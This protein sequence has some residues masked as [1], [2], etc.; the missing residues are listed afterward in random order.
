[1]VPPRP[2]VKLPTVPSNNQFKPTHFAASR[3]LLA[4]ASRRF[5]CA[6]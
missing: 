2:I 6:A 4:Q 5:S 1:M 3:R